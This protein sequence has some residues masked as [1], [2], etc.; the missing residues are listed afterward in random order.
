MN[1]KTNYTFPI[2]ILIIF[3]AVAI[4]DKTKTEKTKTERIIQ[5]GIEN[6]QIIK[7]RDGYTFYA[8]EDNPTLDTRVDLITRYCKGNETCEVEQIFKY[9]TEKPYKISDHDRRTIEVIEGNGGD[10]DEKSYVMASMLK[11]KNHDCVIVY[12]KD[13][14]FIAAKLKDKSNIY[15]N[16]ASLLID[17]DYYFYAETT[18]KGAYLGWFNGRKPNEFKAIYDPINEKEIQP[19]QVTLNI[20]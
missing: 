2:I 18:A 3:I 5:E 15:P 10:C 20:N 13:H 12:T 1:K 19:N 14:A 7:L 16:T 6:K 9:V 4:Y 17:G 11:K 8:V